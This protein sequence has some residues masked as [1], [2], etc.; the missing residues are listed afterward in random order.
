MMATH[1]PCI[2]ELLGRGLDV[3][4]ERRPVRLI[5]SGD[6]QS[7]TTVVG[8]KGPNATMP[9]YQ[10]KSTKAPRIA[11]AAL[12]AKYGTLQDVVGPWHLR[13][14]DQYA[15]CVEDMAN[16][17]EADHLSVTRAPLVSPHP[18]QI[19][20]I[21][22]H[23]T[24]GINSRELRLAV[25]VVI[26]CCGH[27][28]GSAF[29]HEL[30]ELLHEEVHVHPVPYHGGLFIGRD[31][32]AIGEHSDAVCAALERKLSG[33]KG[34]DAAVSRRFLHAYKTAWGLWN[35][36]RK[37]LNSA[38]IVAAGDA[39]AFR[40]DVAA[41]V[42]GLKGSFSWLNVSPK[43]HLLLAHAPYFLDEFGSI[44]LYG[45]QGL[46]AWHGRYTQTARLYPGESDL[47]SAADFVRVMT[48]A[49][50]ASPAVIGRSAHNVDGP[51]IALPW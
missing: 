21:P 44:G 51:E 1:M 31:C 34:E 39:A 5:L 6:Y 3:R 24:L 20:P 22:V 32:H 38:S 9:C 14:A 42:S 8:H 16:L 50:D 27:R 33:L 17:G 37:V 48:L 47:A 26:L 45:E 18:R 46:E 10:C 30:A 41:F 25:E 15:Y 13:D 28:A 12:D 43:L 40:S 4:G 2:D 19:V 23:L 36:I 29:A 11:H 7:Q 49:G 35:R